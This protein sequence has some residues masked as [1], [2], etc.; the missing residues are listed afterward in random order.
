MAKKKA[1]QEVQE[2]QAVQEVQEVQEVKV[3]EKK[4]VI[5]WHTIHIFGYGETQINGDK[6]RKVETSSLTKVEALIDMIYSKKPADSDAGKEYHAITLFKD[7]SCRFSPKES[8]QKG[9][10]ISFQELD[11]AIL[12]E[13]VSEL[14]SLPEPKDVSEEVASEEVK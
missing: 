4:D 1:V 2:V 11:L 9:F 10:S 14:H 3:Q 13:L 7:N 5:K 12:E 8:K 6:E